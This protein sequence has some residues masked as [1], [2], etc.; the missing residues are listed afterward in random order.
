MSDVAA[1]APGGSAA[2]VVVRL[3][4]AWARGGGAAEPDLAAFVAQLDPG[5]EAGL[6]EIVAADLEERRE[7]GLPAGVGHYQRVLG[8]LGGLTV[9]SSVC[10]AVLTYELVNRPDRGEAAVRERLKAQ[11]PELADQID[12][13][14]D[15]F[16]AVGEELEDPPAPEETGK[17]DLVEHLGSGTFGEVWR[18]WDRELE[19]YVALKLLRRPRDEG[20]EAGINRLLAEAQAAA[21]LDHENVVRVHAAGR[22][23]SGGAFY[24]DAQLAGDPAPTAADPRAVAVARPLD[25]AVGEMGGVGGVGCRRAAEIVERACLGVAAAH[26]RGITHRDLKPSNILLT[27]SG[28]VLVTDFGLAAP[29]ARAVDDGDVA[30]TVA[31]DTGDGRIVGTPAYMAPEQ[32]RGEGATPLSDVYA[33]GAVLRFLLT[34]RHPYEPSGSF[35][36]DGRLDVIAQVREGSAGPPPLPGNV[37]ATLSA[38]CRKAMSREPEGRYVSADQMAADLR[39][40]LENRPTLAR[41]LGAM[42]R[43]GLWWRR[44]AAAATAAGVVLLGAVGGTAWYIT[45][46]ERERARAVSAETETARA[47]ERAR[48]EMAK[49]EAVQGFLERMLGAADPRRAGGKATVRE[50]LDAA[51][52]RS[53]VELAEQPEVLAAVRAVIGDTYRTLGLY[54]QAAPHLGAALGIRR[55]VL[56]E[57]H[58]ETLA[59]L[60]MLAQL[61]HERGELAAAEA[62]LRQV[63][64]GLERELGPEA[65]ETLA[66]V[67]KLAYVL[68]DRG[69]LDEAGEL[70]RRAYEGRRRK[71]GDEHL[72]TLVSESDVAGV[73]L[74]QGKPDLAEPL[75]RDVLERQ[76]RILGSDH[77]DTLVTVNDLAL[78]LK[79]QGRLEESGALQRRAVEGMVVRFGEGHFDTLIAMNNLAGLLRAT[80]ELEEAAAVYE[81]LIRVG[82]GS[83][84]AEHYIPQAARGGYGLCL[85][86]LGRIEEAER[87]LLASYEGLHRSLGAE[88]AY[89]VGIRGLLG[90]FYERRGRP[91][92]A[93]RYRE[94]PGGAAGGD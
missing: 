45:A 47:L 15:L 26:A 9:R 58:P 72:E 65:V 38:I 80:G 25:R 90:Q 32:A 77:P 50:L 19:R 68:Q 23:G 56:G 61:E 24:I 16:E 1:G 54:E 39:A 75:L 73:L 8:G 51:A 6:V 94:P 42:G 46:V 7:R 79:R 14:V 17:Y 27:P 81:R 83:L 66:A 88:H 74:L 67:A 21:A 69:T 2:D 49:L 35:H 70:H 62:K 86:K 89:S 52:V 36:D 92:L 41:P 18:A 84:G 78:A 3:R 13:V 76:E 71:L 64:A 29:G 43:S 31:I 87:E 12:L 4:G 44:N 59:S 37:P 40:W 20:E 85:E 60:G 22:L 5:D 30:S 63:V 11:Y 91:E 28:R 48:L 10:Q 57:G 55:G 53:E 34:G 93:E 33:L 82:E